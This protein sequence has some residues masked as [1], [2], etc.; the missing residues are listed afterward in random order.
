MT[1]KT[2]QLILSLFHPITVPLWTLFL[3]F[4]SGS[5]LS[6]LSPEIKRLVYYILGFATVILP[7]LTFGFLYFSRMLPGILGG[8][9]K[10]VF[11]YYGIVTFS[12]FFAW[13]VLNRL[14]LSK[15]ILYSTLILAFSYGVHT[16]V[17]LFSRTSMHLVAWGSASAIILALAIKLHIPFHWGVILLILI[18]GLIGTVLLRTQKAEPFEVYSGWISGFL[19]VFVL[20][21]WF[22]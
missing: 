16:L 15:Y 1:F 17:L 18:A 22:F 4:S 6:Y 13:N 12:L 10:E 19:W 9:K 14:P 21:M 8:N 20:A 7:L 5:Y 3:I 2:S 11:L